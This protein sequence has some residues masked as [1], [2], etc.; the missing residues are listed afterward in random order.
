MARSVEE[1]IGKTDDTAI[2][3]RVR[4]RIFEKTNGH[5]AECG[6]VLRPG[7]WECDHIV[8]LIN[9][10]EHRERNLQPLCDVPCHS[11][12]TKQ[13]SREK[14]VVFRKKAKNLGLKTRKG[15]PMPGSRAS[16]WKRKMSGEVVK[17]ER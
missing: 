12:K 6:R 11:K 17:R 5:C 1:W 3:P 4:I 16:G 9:G 13:D 10:G 2:P 8:A 15:T 7:H 14:S